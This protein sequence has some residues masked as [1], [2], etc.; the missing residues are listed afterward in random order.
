MK[1]IECA[2][3][4]LT[5]DKEARRLWHMTEDKEV[6]LCGYNT[7][8]LFTDP[9]EVAERRENLCL[10]CWELAHKSED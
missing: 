10:D 1:V 5:S 4:D 6:T 9:V 7:L 2:T 3:K 8:Y